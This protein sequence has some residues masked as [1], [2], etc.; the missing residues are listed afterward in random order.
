M[1]KLIICSFL[2]LVF[3]GCNNKDKLTI[4]DTFIED[5]KQSSTKIVIPDFD[6]ND[7]A[8]LL[9]FRNDQFITSNF[10]VNPLSSYY[11]EEVTVGMY[12]LWTIE[13]V[14]ME[15]IKDPNFYLFASLNP[16]VLTESTGATVDQNMILHDVAK[17]Y[18][19]WWNSNLPIEDKLKINPLQVLDLRWS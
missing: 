5:L 19:D 10:P 8:E 16:R 7:I 6:V 13:S 4:V 15:E 11:M 1:R 12:V 9:N 3:I 2:S 18:F 17:A 14:R